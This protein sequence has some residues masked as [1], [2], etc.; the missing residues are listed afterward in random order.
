MAHA[1]PDWSPLLARAAV[2][3][4]SGGSFPRPRVLIATS[5][6]GFG[7]AVTIESLLALALQSRGADVDVLL[8]DAALPV[9]QMC[10][11]ESPEAERDFAAVRRGLLCGACFPPAKRMYE[12]L[13][14]PVHRYSDH[15]TAAEAEQAR[16]VAARLPFET[17]DDYVQDGLAIGEHAV[18]GALRFYGR[19]DFCGE[20]GAE[21]VLRR[22]LEAALRTAA[23]ATRLFETNAYDT[24]VFHHGI[25]VP[26]GLI[27][28]VC[29]RQG[30]RVVNWDTAYRTRS[31]IFSHGQSHHRT[32]A[33]EPTEVWRALALT[34]EQKRTL[35]AYL[36]ARETGTDDWIRFHDGANDDLSGFSRARRLDGRVRIGLLTSVTWDARIHYPSNAFSS[37]MDWIFATIEH[38]AR[39][40][41]LQLL[42]R[43]H[44]AELRGARPA[45]QRVA[46]EVRRKWPVLPHNVTVVGPEDPVSTY[47][48]MESCDTALIYNTKMGVELAARG[49]PVIVAGEAWV[50]G[51]GFTTDVSSA[52]AYEGALA[53]LPAGRRMTAAQVDLAER[54]AYHVF[55]RRMIPLGMIGGGVPVRH[56]LRSWEELTE[57]R[58][59][60][61][62]VICDGILDGREFIFPAERVRAAAV[63]IPRGA[64]QP[65]VRSWLASLAT[66]RLGR[67]WRNT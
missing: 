15:I 47:A 37:M 10:A 32:L 63:T 52:V 49:L 62:D 14:L 24:A 61:L 48:L 11:R 13:G 18:A 38:F 27:G 43:V 21:V 31:F 65:G 67:V 54:Y 7:P 30:V 44:P 34:P 46:E 40:S 22:Y 28:E 39:R 29:R 1:Q 57:G 5:T 12:G 60:G 33:T 26:Q 66:R 17:I 53:G 4:S 51:K 59:P 20:P 9:C 3:V 42:I 16:R 23:V 55:F 50:R 56:T 45:R 25:Y 8:C 58:D 6:G 64:R 2:P 41:E 19:G 35:H 36:R